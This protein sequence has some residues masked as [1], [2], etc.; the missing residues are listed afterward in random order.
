MPAA[1]D[2]IV[3]HLELAR[4]ARL[5]NRP[6][7]CDRL[8]FLA[9]AAAEER[10]RHTIASLCRRAILGHNPGHLIGHYTRFADAIDDQRFTRYLAQLRRRYTSERCE[11]MLASLR[12]N[13]RQRRQRFADLD[14]YVAATL[15]EAADGGVA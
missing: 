4:A 12:I 2:L 7:E 11:H 15:S 8:L 6:W 5:R 14:D 9:G 13:P 10:G 3:M 1:D